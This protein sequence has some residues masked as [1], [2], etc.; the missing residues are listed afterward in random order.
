MKLWQKLSVA[1]GITSAMGVAYW[2]FAIPTHRFQIRSELVMLGT[3]RP[4][5]TTCESPI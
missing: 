1:A 2:K 3:R 5:K 4:R